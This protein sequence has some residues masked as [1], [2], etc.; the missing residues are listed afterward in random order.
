MPYGTFV[1]SARTFVSIGRLA[2]VV[3]ALLFL[4]IE[5]GNRLILVEEN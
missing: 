3:L 5:K 1:S 4:N 2:T